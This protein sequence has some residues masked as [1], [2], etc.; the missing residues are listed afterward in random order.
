MIKDLKII[1]WNVCLGLPNK[2]NNIK[3]VIEMRKPDIIFLQETELPLNYNLDL[4]KING[5]KLTTS[6]NSP[7]KRTVCYSSSH[8]N[9]EIETPEGLELI[10]LE[11]QRNIIVGIY[12]PFKSHCTQKDYMISL[13]NYL[14]AYL[15]NKNKTVFMTGDLNLDYEEKANIHYHNY[16]I[17]NVW[18]QL[19]IENS[20][21]QLVAE[22]TWHRMVNGTPRLSI[23]DHFYTNEIN[24]VQIHILDTSLS[25]HF[26]VE[27]TISNAKENPLNKKESC[28]VRNWK[29]YTPETLNEI[30]K[31]YDWKSLEKK[32]SPRT[33]RL[34]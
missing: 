20:F 30:L 33:C 4:L 2:I 34:Y 21:H 19:I 9:Y 7:K 23:L 10:L 27:A 3:D 13:S 11:D 14:R 8:L 12:R 17:Y 26:L 22:P 16:A 28:Y 1:S 31:N 18:N 24:Q 25:D 32:T 6:N 29:K 15:N 5:Y